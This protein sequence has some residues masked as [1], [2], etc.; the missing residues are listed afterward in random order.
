M[1]SSA[2]REA[3]NTMIERGKSAEHFRLLSD[4]GAKQVLSQPNN[5]LNQ[6]VAWKE[7]SHSTKIRYVSN[8][9]SINKDI[10]SSLKIAQK[11][12]GNIVNSSEWPLNYFMMHTAAYS[13][14]VKSAY[15]KLQVSKGDRRFQLLIFFYFSKS[16]W[17][18]FPIIVEQINLPFGV[19]QAGNSV[20]FSTGR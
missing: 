11:N 18:N 16:D 20:S 6:T 17:M 8:P 4:E 14:D 9:S 15:R 10:C 13:C 1:S 5:F 19:K 3:V 7:A 12:P 2:G